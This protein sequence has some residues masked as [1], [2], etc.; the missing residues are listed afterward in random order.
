[1]ST[2]AWSSVPVSLVA[3]VMLLM[4]KPVQNHTIDNIG[5]YILTNLLSN[6]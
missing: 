1:M 2:R 4:L 6:V 3:S 5:I